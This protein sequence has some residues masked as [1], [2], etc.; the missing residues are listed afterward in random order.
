[1][2]GMLSSMSSRRS[3][4]AGAPS[5]FS[6]QEES[7]GD[8]DT[9]LLSGYVSSSSSSDGSGS[10]SSAGKLAR[11]LQLV[12][13]AMAG[14]K[15][16]RLASRS[17][18][19][20]DSN[21]IPGSATSSMVAGGTCTSNRFTTASKEDATNRY[22]TAASN[23][24]SSKDIPCSGVVLSKTKGSHQGTLV[25]PAASSTK[26]AGHHSGS[27]SGSSMLSGM[28]CLESISGSDDSSNNDSNSS[29]SS[30]SSSSA[31]T[32]PKAAAVQS[33]DG[34]SKTLGSGSWAKR[35]H[36]GSG[37]L[38]KRVLRCH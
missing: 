7:F 30:S 17:P 2:S 22:N 34:L 21:S 23:S 11:L 32:C 24:S 18:S 35:L 28:P 31:I 13:G 33:V 25:T 27:S 4:M 19:I 38:L 14:Q 1:M 3:S 29:S 36:K 12:M 5:N 9:P 15:G 10:G 37:K 26:A 6:S 8:E 16:S 20:G